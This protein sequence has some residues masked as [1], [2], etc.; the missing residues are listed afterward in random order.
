MKKHMLAI[1]L[2]TGMAA[3]AVPASAQVYV[4]VAPPVTIVETVPAAPGSGYVWVNGHY[5]W[6]GKRYVW[7]GG[8]YERHGGR[9]CGGHW[10]HD[11]QGYIWVDGRWC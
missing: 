4:R 6:N 10:R 8:H 2:L 7:A 3:V 5:N 1:F 9:W 11:A